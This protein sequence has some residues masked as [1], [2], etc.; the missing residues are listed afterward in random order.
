MVIWLVVIRLVIRLLICLGVIVSSSLFEVWGLVVRF[1]LVLLFFIRWVVMNFRLWLVL[2][3]RKF[4]VISSRALG[5]S[6]SMVRSILVVM[7]VVSVILCRWLV[8]L[9][10]VMLV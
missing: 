1:W 9:N 5:S 10:L 6:G 2:L 4:L 7:L 8:S 3:G